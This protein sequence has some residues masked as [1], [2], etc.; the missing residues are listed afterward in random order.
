MNNNE[1]VNKMLNLDKVQ[2][3]HADFEDAEKVTLYVE[4]TLAAGI[5]PECGKICSKVHDLSEAQMIR[6]LS[7]ADRRCYLSYQAR[8]YDCQHC[9]TTFVERV[10][11]KRTGTSYTLRYEHYIYQR[12]R[13]E[14]VSQ[15]A[16]D[17]GL[18]EETVQAIFEHWAK[19]RLR[20][21]GI[22]KSR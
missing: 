9:N 13:Q 4:S 1:I 12:S 20:H 5:C 16:Q 6:D 7:V 18:S 22:R 11:W 10:E 19:K 2:V 3:T 21:G 8:R 15:I 17:E 14:P